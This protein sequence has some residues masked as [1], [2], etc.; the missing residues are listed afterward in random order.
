MFKNL[1]KIAA[2][3]KPKKEQSPPV[4]SEKV[5][6]VSPAVNHVNKK[7]EVIEFGPIGNNAKAFRNPERKDSL[8]VQDIASLSSRQT[9]ALA[10]TERYLEVLCRRWREDRVGADTKTAAANRCQADQGNHQTDHTDGENSVS[11]GENGDPPKHTRKPYRE[12]AHPHRSS[13]SFSPLSK[14]DLPID[15]WLQGHCS[16]HTFAEPEWRCAFIWLWLQKNCLAW[17]LHELQ[18]QLNADTKRQGKRLRDDE[19][20]SNPNSTSPPAAINLRSLDSDRRQQVLKDVSP[21]VLALAEDAQPVLAQLEMWSEGNLSTTNN[22][23]NTRGLVENNTKVEYKIPATIRN[24]LV[25]VFLH[26]AHKQYEAAENIYFTIALG[27]QSWRIGA[28]MGGAI[29]TRATQEKFQ[30]GA[31]SH[32]MND[33][34]ARSALL[35]VKTIVNI[36]A[37][38][39]RDT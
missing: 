36:S 17:E 34:V 13:N 35:A 26:V 9:Q 20:A 4:Q 5:G 1:A 14:N 18:A 10:R 30:R 6:E 8:S 25:N 7:P 29:H 27:N 11:R 21:L 15:S 33:Q 19:T 37:A 38:L 2:T 22:D 39:L 32:V 16:T 31:V 12:E 23:E 28:N 24:P 3:A